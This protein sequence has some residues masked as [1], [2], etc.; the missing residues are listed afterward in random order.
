MRLLD[1][2]V[3]ARTEPALASIAGQKSALIAVPEGAR[4]LILAALGHT[5]SRHPIVIAAPTGTAAR[6]IY[7]DMRNFVDPDDIVLFPAWETLPFERVS[8]SIDTM[9]KRMEVLWRLRTPSRSPKF[10]ITGVRA[11]LQKLAPNANNV[12]PIT[13][14]RSDNC[15]IDSLCE[16]LVHCG[17]RRE[18]LVEHRGE[19]ARRGAIVDV[20]PSTMDEP[21]RIDMWG[22]EID[23]LTHFTV[24]D[25]RSTDD[26]EHVEIF[27]AR[28]LLLA[29]DVRALA[30]TLVGTE[31]WGREQWE[32]LAEGQTFDGM[33]SWLPW[34]VTKQTLLTDFLSDDALMV[35]IEPRRMIDRARDLL[36]EEDDLARA[37]AQSWAR[38]ATVEF[39]RLH[40]EP[41]RLL[42][43]GMRFPTINI[44][45]TPESPMSPSVS[46]SGWGAIGGPE[47][48]AR[49]INE[50]LADKWSIIVL[51]E[52]QATVDRLVDMMREHGLDFTAASANTDLT[53][54]GAYVVHAIMGRGISLT[55]IKLALITEGDLTGRR[56]GRREQLAK[57]SKKRSAV[58]VFEDLQPGGY[59]VHQHHGVGRYEGMVTRS[60]SGVERDYLLLAYKGGDK[61]YV[62]TD[63]IDSV[64][65]YI[66][67]E[68]P[69]P[70]RLGG[71]DFARAK[72]RVRSAVRAVAQELV[73]LYQRRVTAKGHAFAADTPWQ[74]EMESAFPFVET[75]DQLTAITNIKSDMEQDIPMDR[76][77]CGD[78]GFGKT[79]V[80]IRAAFKAIQDGKQVAVLVP[81]TLL[82]TQHGVTFSDRF[83]G[84]PIRVEVLSRFLTNAMA[85]KVITG[86]KTGEVDCVIGTH[87]LLQEGIRFKDLGLLIVDEE[88][89]FGVQHKEAMKRMRTDVDVLTMSATP[90]PR[91][92]EMSLVGIRDLSL[93]Q[94]PP[95]DRQPILT[96]VSEDNERVA[97]EALRRELLREGQVFWVHNRVKSI[98]ERAAE[99]RELV[100]EARIAVAHGQMDEG[101]LEQVVLDFWNHEYDVLVCTTI[102]ESGID[103]PTVNTLVVERADLL[104]LGQL[105]QLRGRAGRSGQRAYAYLFH[106]QDKILSEDAYER[107]RTIGEATDLGS[108]FKIAMRDLEIRGAGNLLGEAQSGHIAAVGYDLYCQ[109]VTEAVAEMKGEVAPPRFELKIDIPV[110]AHLP[111]DYV[112][113]EE[114]R[115]EAY[116]R[117][118][119]VTTILEVNDIEQEWID[120]FGPLPL[121]A[122]RLLQVATLRAECHRCQFTELVVNN[123]EIR[124]SPVQ[125]RASQTMTLKRISPSANFR[126]TQRQLLLPLPNNIDITTHL[127]SLI[128]ELFEPADH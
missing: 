41:E 21:I 78:V 24:N 104:G 46:A 74:S 8:P 114:L 9:G 35:L 79:E 94:T 26:V 98:Q 126:E 89:R 70:H 44:T 12:D 6:E 84:Y 68:S 115:L 2:A 50:L 49:R 76:L 92:L 124:I 85:K 103:M 90:I 60:I 73:V 38:D 55:N 110:D 108:G 34:L 43:E 127:I 19:F 16:Q 54:P 77:L 10:I 40:T 72:S 32:R 87:R 105:H 97:I 80:A 95:A 86:L 22:D 4:P 7:A 83:A 30:A 120:R 112:P 111:H 14:R 59:V 42:S 82:A 75:P 128:N 15:D 36:A 39:P 18:T 58:T 81:T 52:T 123:R 88:Q 11:L 45:T 27:P 106:P 117:L 1:L 109:M 13:V 65:Q 63:Q 29:D 17:Y 48:I 99:L 31:P 53:K 119:D 100:P 51:A 107:L 69:T 5:T 3:L 116:R 96:Y 20:F 101:T 118:G 67:G 122:S 113:S 121:P 23:R 93:L 25:Q 57:N 28:E 47:P 56:R 71:I 91:T 102:I 125:L 33:E 61:L 64:R 37:L 62:P 66:G